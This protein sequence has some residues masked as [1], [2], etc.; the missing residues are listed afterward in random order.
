VLAII[1]VN[2]PSSAKRR[3]APLL[4]ARQRAALVE[5]MLADVVAACKATAAVERVLVVTPDSTLAPP[6]T[7]LLVDVGRGHAAAIAEGLRQ[8]RSDGALVV[9]ADCPLVRHETLDLLCDAARPV[10]L[11]PAQDGGTN[12]VALRPHDVVEPAF[13]IPRGAAV[14]TRRG[15]HLGLEVSIVDDPLLALDVDTPADVERVLDLGPSTR[16]ATF[17]DSVLALPAE[18]GLERR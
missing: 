17:L 8:C 1:P 6:D 5:A 2:S 12:A 7:D 15:R 10:A 18:L 4:T 13:G 14:L 16:T 9:M 3:L 11:A